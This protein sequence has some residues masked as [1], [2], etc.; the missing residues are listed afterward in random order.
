MKQT[1]YLKPVVRALTALNDMLWFSRFTGHQA[2]DDVEAKV[3]ESPGALTTHCFPNNPFAARF[4]VRL[5]D[6]SE[7]GI[8]HDEML[9]RVVYGCS[10]EYYSRHRERML[11][12][13]KLCGSKGWER[14]QKG[15]DKEPKTP[16]ER[17]NGAL[18][19]HGYDEM[20]HRHILTAGYARVRRNQYFHAADSTS[21]VMGGILRTS[22]LTL[23]KL[24]S[25]QPAVNQVDFT[26]DRLD[27]TSAVEAVGLLRMLL[28]LTKEI[29]AHTVGLL[30]E[31]KLVR[32]SLKHWI[33]EEKSGELSAG[34]GRVTRMRARFRNELSIVLT[35]EDVER[36]LSLN[37]SLP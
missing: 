7:H 21:G 30:D 27:G 32:R 25:A 19:R 23:N 11:E 1:C 3:R 9:F 2:K 37:S 24:W 4:N 20:N 34:P 6:V 17:F 35:R 29:D 10:Y 12:L 26:H 22:G 33:E 36:L 31:D 5:D 14:T 18:S 28:I 8:R 15:E 16:E 13:L